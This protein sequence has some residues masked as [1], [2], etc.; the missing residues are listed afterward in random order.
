MNILTDYQQALLDRNALA[1][2]K[3]KIPDREIEEMYFYAFRY[4]LGRTTC[5]ADTVANTIIKRIRSFDDYY[6]NR[7]CREIDDAI[8][9]KAAGMECDIKA[10]KRLYEEANTELMVRLCEGT[11]WKL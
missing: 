9:R 8:E 11:R 10:W 6:L 5:A 4:A 3:A 2:E 1:L 7:I